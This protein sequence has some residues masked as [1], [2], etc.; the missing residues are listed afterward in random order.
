M[1]AYTAMLMG[2]SLAA[3]GCLGTDPVDVD[4]NV[5]VLEYMQVEPGFGENGRTRIAW[6]H[7]AGPD[8]LQGFH[9]TI[10]FTTRVGDDTHVFSRTTSDEDRLLAGDIVEYTYFVGRD[11]MEA[12]AEHGDAAGRVSVY[13]CFGPDWECFRK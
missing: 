12:R 2:V 8:A 7:P 13:D 10:R 6:S 4:M 11:V 1:K 5:P 9:G 3:A